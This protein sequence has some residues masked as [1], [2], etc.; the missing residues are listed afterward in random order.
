MGADMRAA[1]ASLREPV[2]WH[3]IK[4]DKVNRN[5][6][7]LQVRIVKALREGKTRL[8]RALQYILTR[9]FGG[10]ALAVRR[11]T[12]NKG[13]RTAG[14]DGE[15]WNT[16]ECKSKGILK[17]R[18]KGYRASPLRRV[19]IPK[20]NGKK[21]PL[22]IP[23]MID[24][25]F[26]ALWKLALEPITESLADPNSYGFRE[27]RSTADAIEQCFICLCKK[28]SATWIYEGDIR[29]CFDRIKRKW[30][31]N[32][33]PMDKKILN[34]WL[35]SGFIEKGKLYPTEDGTPQGGIISP[36]LA[37]I[38]L[39]G[40]EN[41]LKNAFSSHDKVHLIRFADD[42]IITGN[43][44]E[45]LEN[46]VAPIV[47]E[48]YGVRGLE[49]AEEKTHITHIEQ[50]F[51]FLGQNIR[52]YN[53]KL[54]IKPSKKSINNLLKKVKGIIKNSSGKKPIHL[55]WELNPVIRGWANFHRHVVSKAIFG[56]VDFEITK[57]LWKWAKH[58]HP[59]MPVN[60]VKQKYF[61]QT[62]R[63]RDWCFFGRKGD[64]KATLTKAMDVKIKRHT[65]IKG[66]AN[67]Y[68]PE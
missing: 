30:L 5:V 45:L 59:K 12:E 49:L 8:V 31:L 43:T 4:W 24:R 26:Q 27:C 58:R 7:R 66:M 46:K 39:D 56:K 54:I 51:D 16:P 42:F 22:G 35:K 33:V 6:R 40:L 20:S 64:K 65:K 21:R 55:I 67:P 62:E 17:L 34:Q 68:D 48:H 3:K 38:A 13:K 14:V 2:D 1:G 19:H 29:A 25:A 57:T 23:T 15:I 18:K 41:K 47:E 44:K 10:R 53:G 60:R 28:G 52:K 36:V 50:G 61:Y 11:V 32:N 9:S 37:N 63:G